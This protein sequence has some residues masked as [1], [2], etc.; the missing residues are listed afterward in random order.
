[1]KENI[2]IGLPPPAQPFSWAV[3]AAGLLFTT[4]GPVLP[5]GSI[6]TGPIGQQA[7]ITLQN[8]QRAVEAAGA[9]MRDV[10]Q[11]L[12]YLVDEND[13]AAVDAVYREFFAPPY[14]NRSSVA[15]RSLVAPGMRIEMVVYAAVPGT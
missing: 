3:K 12:I 15:V 13:M 2:D 7:R 11:V 10:A 8:V 6:D 14:P 1:M 5:D 9:R 4:H